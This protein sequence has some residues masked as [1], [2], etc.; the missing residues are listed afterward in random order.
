M[1]KVIRS[2]ILKGIAFAVCLICVAVAA[3][4]AG[5]TL[6]WFED[7]TMKRGGN[8]IYLLEPSFIV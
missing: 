6:E 8:S 3:V 5:N 7:Q 4:K 1:K 2:P